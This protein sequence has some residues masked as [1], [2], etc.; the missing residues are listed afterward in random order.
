MYCPARIVESY[1]RALTT[2][3]AG[4]N[5]QK[6]NASAGTKPAQ[7]VREKAPAA[8]GQEPAQAEPDEAG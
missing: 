2:Q 5:G 7:P 3:I 6:K 4:G 8:N 1:I